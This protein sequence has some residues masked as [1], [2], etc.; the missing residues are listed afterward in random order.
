ETLAGLEVANV[1]DPATLLFY[2]AAAE[3]HLLKKD[4]CLADVRLLPQRENELP[5]RF[6]KLAQLMQAD[7]EP[8]K[9]DSVDEIARLMQVVERRLD[10]GR[11]GTRVR[12]E[13]QQIV[14][15]LDKLIENIEQQMQQMQQQQQQQQQSGSPT[16]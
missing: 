12:E 7:M 13:E 9:A 1:C 11:A 4:E 15:K 10:L 3:H 5:S 16:P 6:A 2:R 8:L 14:D